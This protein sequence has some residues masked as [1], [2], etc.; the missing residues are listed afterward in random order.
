M[1]V[2]APIA[3]SLSGDLAL[4]LDLAS[5]SSSAAPAALI[6]AIESS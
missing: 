1:L 3:E 2:T 5:S 4:A 6:L